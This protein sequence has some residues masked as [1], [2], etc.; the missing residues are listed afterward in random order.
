M[1]F[2]LRKYH[3]YNFF[4]FLFN[5]KGNRIIFISYYGKQY[6]DNPKWLYE[7]CL[8]KDLDLEYIW[9]LNDIEY[10]KIKKHPNLKVIKSSSI[11]W[12]YY[13]ATSKYWVNNCNM[14]SEI[15]PPKDTIYLQTWH[16]TPLKKIGLDITVDTSKQMQ[17]YL[18]DIR[19]EVKNW[20]YIISSSLKVSRILKS[21][22]GVT[23]SQIIEC[24]YPR[25]DIL[26]GNNLTDKRNEILKK[27]H[28]D[29]NEKKIILY[30]PTF[31][32]TED[33]FN[34]EMDKI[35]LK[36]ELENDYIFLFRKHS[37]IKKI[38][39]SLVND[40]F[41]INVSD[42]DDIQELYVISDILITDYSS[43]FFDFALLERLMIFYP[44]DFERYQDE[45]RGF[46]FNY[47]ETVPGPITRTTEG[48]LNIIRNS[49]K[50][51]MKYKLKIK[52][53]NSTFN[54]S[55]EGEGS[56]KIMELLGL[57]EKS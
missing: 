18:K 52:K 51:I 27:L 23:D 4:K 20:S 38:N 15:I 50:N 3:I 36:N 41:Y 46:Y 53:F 44:Y 22:F 32:T 55:L 57:N 12:L 13:M 17:R 47:D 21:A 35:L 56:K 30:A 14:A 39:P 8:S 24:N 48:I 6:S 26:L 9:V 5:V 19:S 2:K 7:Y 34:I 54:S 45:L 49:E 29:N 37:N 33:E 11:K 42:Y 28:L 43:V 31:R 25:N 1:K 10:S 40:S 16:G